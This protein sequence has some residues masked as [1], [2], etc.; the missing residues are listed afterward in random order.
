MSFMNLSLLAQG[1]LT[2]PVIDNLGS[3]PDAARDGSLFFHYAIRMWR[4]AITL[5]AVVVLAYYV[6]AAFEW[7]SS[8]GDSKGVEKA[9]TRFTQAT[10]GL[11]LLV[12]SFAII[13]FVS[14]LLFG[15][16]FNL[17]QITIPSA[18]EQQTNNPGI[19]EGRPPHI[20][21]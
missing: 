10:I 11:I 9:K 18:T 13:A 17:L 1:S 3:D 2:N 8:G 16:D 12:G 5:G 7:L 4:V 15:D 20:P 21:T 6:M 19:P 14:T